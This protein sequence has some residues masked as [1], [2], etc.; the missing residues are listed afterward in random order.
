M[1]TKTVHS[2]THGLPGVSQGRPPLS[3]IFL[4][5]WTEAK[6]LYRRWNNRREIRA[7]M[8]LDDHLL[9]DMGITRYDVL[10]AGNTPLSQSPG[11]ALRKMATRR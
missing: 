8:D 4:G 10:R 2:V 3:A 7:M 6:T 11:E 9:C 1:T 5:A